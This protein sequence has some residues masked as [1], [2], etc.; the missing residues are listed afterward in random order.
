[1]GPKPERGVRRGITFVPRQ[2]TRAI[3]SEPPRA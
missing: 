2:G 3:L 1:V